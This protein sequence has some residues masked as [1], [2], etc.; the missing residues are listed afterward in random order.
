MELT[1]ARFK[2][3]AQVE[4]DNARTQKFLRLLPIRLSARRDAAYRSFAD[5]EAAHAYGHA[6]RGEAIERLP[7]L[8]K[9][10]EANAEANGA[11]VFWAADSDAANAYIVDLARRKGARYV[12]KGKSMITEEL[13]LN[14]ALAAAGITAWETD[15]GEF[16]AQLLEKPPFHIVG[17]AINIPVEQIRDIFMARGVL[18]TP[19]IDPVT[20]GRAARRFLRDKF[21]DLR[22]GVTGVNIAVADTGT[23]INV[24]NEGNIRFNKSSPRTLVC[25]MSLEKVVPTMADALH[26]LRVLCRSATGQ[27]AGAYITFDSGPRREGESDGPEE[28]HIIVLDNGRSAMAAD[29]HTREVLRCIRCG[30]CLNAC[31]VYGK[32]GGYPY[33]WAYSGPMG[34][35]LTPALRGLADTGDLIRACTLCHRCKVICP[36]GIDHPATL[37]YYRHK[38][39][40]ADPQMG[41][42]GRSAM[43]RLA[44][45]GH[46]FVGSHPRLWR[47]FARIVRR[48]ANRHAHD[49]TISRIT[50][51][52]EGWFSS[53]D[54]PLLPQDTFHDR[55]R[56]G[57]AARKPRKEVSS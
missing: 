49:G 21:R 55:W 19:T 28:L 4:L 22:M 12:T 30:A 27:A 11:L 44:Y 56:Q 26:M 34:Q 9:T 16:I 32:V 47:L 48:V 41:G 57:A 52:T 15:L 33:G 51:R 23:V 25:V 3:T 46:A 54:L 8:L 24:E 5:P 20:L 31:P 10:F 37:L 18:D 13:G 39:V 7:E 38:D 50:R 17:P 36:A 6:I 40:Q 42:R 53:R 43:E 45:W 35:V 14:D 1:T 2:E 29:P